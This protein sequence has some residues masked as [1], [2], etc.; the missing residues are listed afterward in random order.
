MSEPL[1][2]Y[3]FYCTKHKQDMVEFDTHRGMPSYRCE[4]CVAAAREK[5]KLERDS[6]NKSRSGFGSRRKPRRYG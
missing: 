2:A 4:A 5:V 1:P 3:Y 6:F